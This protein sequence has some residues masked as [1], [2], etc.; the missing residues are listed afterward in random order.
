MTEQ[1]TIQEFYDKTLAFQ[2]KAMENSASYN[3]VIVLAGYAAFF[4]IWSSVVNEVPR[5][6][7][8]CSGGLILFS[9]IG[10]VGW[11]VANM[12][13]LK[14]Y[15]TEMAQCVI[16]GIEGFVERVTE[17]ERAHLVRQGKVMAWWSAT[18]ALT[19]GT[20]LIATVI[21]AG[22]ALAGLLH[23]QFTCQ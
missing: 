8:L 11:T 19:A 18:V 1:L 15:Y 21:L 23:F 10:Y 7:V 13:L 14:S 3:Q 6:V 2:A 22:S 20:A 16:A 5:W 9:V 12:I 4:A 17:V